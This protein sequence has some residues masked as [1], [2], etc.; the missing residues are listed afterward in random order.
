MELGGKRTNIFI[1]LTIHDSQLIVIVKAL[2]ID[3]QI[4]ICLHCAESGLTIAGVNTIFAVRFR[5]S[6][7]IWLKLLLSHYQLAH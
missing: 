2:H 3:G 1:E 7:G 4:K 6:A 5:T